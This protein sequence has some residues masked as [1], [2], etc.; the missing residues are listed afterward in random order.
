MSI[1]NLDAYD[2]TY[3]LSL[4]L[5]LSHFIQK[6]VLHK[7][8]DVLITIA[9]AIGS[10]LA[11]VRLC[12]V[13]CLW[14]VFGSFLRLGETL[15]IIAITW[16]L[17]KDTY[18]ILC[19]YC[20]F[21]M[22]HTNIVNSILELETKK[23][24]SKLWFWKL[25]IIGLH[26]C[27]SSRLDSKQIPLYICTGV[28]DFVWNI[29]IRYYLVHYCNSL[30]LLY[31]YNYASKLAACILPLAHPHECLANCEVCPCSICQEKI[32]HII[33]LNC[34]HCFCEKCIKS[35]VQT[36]VSKDVVAS[37]PACRTAI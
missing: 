11:V 14:I 36:C 8:M 29:C 26:W 25:C 31:Y 4:R 37:C 5:G 21:W 10:I 34:N 32:L 2:E 35:W 17:S 22:F 15:N 13:V 30:Q 33:K 3:V 27:L 18:W 20:V 23:V 24:C 16:Y 1:S 7:I 12:L 6:A 19:M 9:M 28:F